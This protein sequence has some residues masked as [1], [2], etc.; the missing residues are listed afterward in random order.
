MNPGFLRAKALL[1]S[2]AL[3]CACLAGCSSRSSQP[4]GIAGLFLPVEVKA[5]SKKNGV[6]YRYV[7]VPYLLN[8]ETGHIDLG[9]IV[10]RENSSRNAQAAAAADKLKPVA[11]L[12]S[13]SALASLVWFDYILDAGAIAKGLEGASL[14]P[15]AQAAVK[16]NSFAQTFVSVRLGLW[17]LAWWQHN[18]NGEGRAGPLWACFG[19]KRY[20]SRGGAPILFWYPLW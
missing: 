16:Q 6:E 10:R 17:G 11:F 18:V 14:D 8:A 15:A 5:A 20:P 2:A 19:W 13:R 1:A 12:W 7:G 9:G 4:S 3:L